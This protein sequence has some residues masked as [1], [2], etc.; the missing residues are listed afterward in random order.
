[1]SESLKIQSNFAILDVKGGRDEL[2]SKVIKGENVKLYLTVKVIGVWGE[3]DGVSR[4][5]CLDVID[6][7]ELQF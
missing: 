3:D 5:F 4:E 2:T 1:M 6:V 7:E